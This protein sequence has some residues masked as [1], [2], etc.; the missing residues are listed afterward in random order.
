MLQTP[1]LKSTW[2]GGGRVRVR[3]VPVTA[4]SVLLGCGPYFSSYTLLAL[5][6][7]DGQPIELRILQRCGANSEMV[8]SAGASSCTSCHL[9]PQAIQMVPR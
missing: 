1:P 5:A 8:Q 4:S 7:W 2:L 6:E 3:D 9:L